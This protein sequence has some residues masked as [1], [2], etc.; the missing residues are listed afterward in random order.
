MYIT[1]KLN[2]FT[3]RKMECHSPIAKKDISNFNTILCNLF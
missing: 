2:E 1:R 3:R